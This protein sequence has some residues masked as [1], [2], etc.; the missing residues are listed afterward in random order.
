MLACSPA[1]AAAG[2]L[3]V[4]SC[5]HKRAMVLQVKTLPRN[6]HAV[7]D[8]GE[9]NVAQST[10]R[11]RASVCR[12]PSRAAASKAA[13]PPSLSACSSALN[14]G[15]STTAIRRS[16][17]QQLE[18][19]PHQDLAPCHTCDDTLCLRAD[20]IP[21]LKVA[22]PVLRK[23]RWSSVSQQTSCNFSAH[24]YAATAYLLGAALSA[25]GDLRHVGWRRLIWG[26]A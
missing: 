1:L 9:C 5:M 21:R 10:C 4:K 14:N 24:W 19:I 17:M 23:V 18:R 26:P 16:N 20:K 8:I 3:L 7:Y 15:S 11:D 25:S 6:H 13:A 12:S 22:C 2:Q